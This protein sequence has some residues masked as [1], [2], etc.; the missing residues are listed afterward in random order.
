MFWKQ[1]I[2]LPSRSKVS[3]TAGKPY[4][5]QPCSEAQ[6]AICVVPDIQKFIRQYA[7]LIATSTDHQLNTDCP[8]VRNGGG[9]DRF[10]IV[11]RL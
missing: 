4:R 7:L 3:V 11:S 2:T 1:G 5:L 6:L 8:V 10:G 9:C